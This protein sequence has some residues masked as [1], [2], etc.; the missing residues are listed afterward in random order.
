MER[1]C[2]GSELAGFDVALKGFV[3]CFLIF[4]FFVFMSGLDFVVHGVLYGYGL[5]FSFDWAFL[6]WNVYACVFFA[7]GLAMSFVYWLGSGRS[8]R[9]LKVSFGLFLSVCLLFFGGL[10]DVLWFM[11]WGAGLPSD[12]VVWWWM[13]WYRVFGFWNSF[14]QLVLLFCTFGVLFLFWFLAL[15]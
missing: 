2:L 3:L 15:R 4:L 11:F 1:C 13:P 8:W 12:N 9:D 7:F 10:A 6:Y 14:A 5:R